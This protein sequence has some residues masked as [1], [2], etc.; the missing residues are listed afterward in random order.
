M[1][2]T[3]PSDHNTVHGACG[4][5]WKQRGNT[6]GHCSRCH[7]TFEGLSVFD[8]HFFTDTDG[9]RKCR[10]PSEVKIG[11]VPLRLENASWRGPRMPEDVREKYREKQ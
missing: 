8:A 9:K 11:G 4:R 5:S 6:T 2:S 3:L 1:M 7:E 10:H